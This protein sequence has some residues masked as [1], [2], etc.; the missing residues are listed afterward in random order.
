MATLRKRVS[1]SGDVSWMVRVRLKGHPPEAAT[2]KRK[3]DAKRWGEKT[4]AAIREGRHFATAEAKRHTAGELID[5]YTREVLPRK[6][7]SLKQQSNQLEWWKAHIGDYRLSDVTPALITETRAALLETVTREGTKF[8]ASNANRYM[9]ALGHVFTVAIKEFQ[10]ARTNPVQQIAKL[11][12]PR[13]RIRFLSDDERARLLTECKADPHPHLYT[14][15]IIALSTGARKNEILSLRWPNVDLERGAFTLHD[16]KNSEPRRLPLTGL[17]LDLM[18]EKSRLRRIDCDY[19]FAQKHKPKPCDIDREFARARDRAGIEDFRFHDTRHSAASY[20]AMNGASLAEIAATLGHKT[21]TM[22]AR[23]SHLS[24]DH[25]SDVV[26]RMNEQ[27]LGE[28]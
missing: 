12:E 28:K 15:V 3:T 27:I 16:T 13:G 20:L 14:V 25:I 17:A 24:D 4:E 7:R 11:K 6:P 9:S 26:T 22:V 10:W 21:L 5:R 2:F 19:V 18:R 23:Y 1:S 8:S